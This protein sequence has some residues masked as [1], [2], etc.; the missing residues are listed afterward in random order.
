MIPA[1]RPLIP[2]RPFPL[3]VK[4]TRYPWGLPKE[5]RMT[6]V[7][8]FCVR[9]GVLI[10]ADTEHAGPVNLHESKIIMSPI[11]KNGRVVFA[12]TAENSHLARAAIQWAIYDLY[13]HHKPIDSPFAMA[14]IIEKRLEGEYRRH[15]SPDINATDNSAYQIMFAAWHPKGKIEM[16]ESWKGSVQ[17]RS[18]HAFLG[19]GQYVASYVVGA[20]IEPNMDTER[21]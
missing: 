18:G 21:A 4:H 8:G 20:T 3:P 17:N 7:V 16:F 6:I 10:C 19:M 5:K 9:D 13:Q 2:K 15:V 12:Y 11:M 14:S 1:I